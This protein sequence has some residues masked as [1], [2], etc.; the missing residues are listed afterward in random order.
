MMARLKVRVTKIEARRGQSGSYAIA[1]LAGGRQAYVWDRAL[2]QTLSTPG[3]YEL[4]V[5]ERRGFLRIVSARPVASTN[6]AQGHDA[7]GRV[8]HE[9][10][11]ASMAPGSTQE[12]MVALQAAVALAPHFGY[13][14]VGQV[15]SV[16]ERMVRWLRRG[17]G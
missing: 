7:Q 15:L 2:V 9:P 11:E 14:D 3:L 17:E 10:Q 13:T 8:T 5:V 16:A 4:E 6:G 12:R 1:H